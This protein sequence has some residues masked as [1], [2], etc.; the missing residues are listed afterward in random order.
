MVVAEYM[1]LEPSINIADV[2]AREKENYNYIYPVA[3]VSYLKLCD[4]R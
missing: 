4:I 2:V 1:A 3:R